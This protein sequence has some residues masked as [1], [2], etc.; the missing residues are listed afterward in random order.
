MRKDQQYKYCTPASHRIKV[1]KTIDGIT[2]RTL[3]ILA[4][5]ALLSLAVFVT[6][7]GIM[8]LLMTILFIAKS[9]LDAN[10]VLVCIGNLASFGLLFLIANTIVL[11]VRKLQQNSNPFQ[12]YSAIILLMAVFGLG[13]VLIAVQG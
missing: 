8:L 13:M 10:L 5:I 2:L 7:V 12:F 1:I 3:L 4:L 11:T 6:G 9:Q